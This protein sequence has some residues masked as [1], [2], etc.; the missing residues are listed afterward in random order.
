MPVLVACKGFWGATTMSDRRRSVR[1]AA[2]VSTILSAPAVATGAGVIAL[3]A[4]L[5]VAQ[6]Q[7]TASQI[8][9]YVVGA[10]GQP[11]AGAAVEIVHVPTG[12]VSH[13]TTTD[14]GQFLATG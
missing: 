1:L 3:L 9:G 10:D 12:T 5:P 4:A 8:S 14:S 7:E 13:E 11:V 6:A 2:A